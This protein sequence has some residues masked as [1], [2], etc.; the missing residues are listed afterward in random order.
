VNARFTMEDVRSHTYKRRDAWWTVF[1]VDPLAGRLVMFTANRSSLTPNSLSTGAL[2]LG[3]GAAW[4]FWEADTPWLI[5][6]AVLYHLSFVLDCMDGKIAR[7]KGTGT[8]FGGWLDYVFDRIRVLVCAVA[9]TA[10]RF[11]A[12][13]RPIYLGLGVVIVF[14]DMLRYLDALKV[15]AVRREMRAKLENAYRTAGAVDERRIDRSFPDDPDESEPPVVR[16]ADLQRGF[17]SRFGWYMGIRDW[18]VRHRIRPHLVSGI[19]FQMAVFIIGP[20]CQAIIPVTVVAGLLMLAFEVAIIYKLWLS[21]RDF[22]R[23]M[24]DLEVAE[25]AA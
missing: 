5:V 23:M 3:L 20:V 6:G 1:L 19:E 18:L 24:G 4:C 12:T 25:R 21:T 17:H 22:A 9:L 2:G 7:L 14:L 13:G 16:L 15:A 8:V 10:G 11:E